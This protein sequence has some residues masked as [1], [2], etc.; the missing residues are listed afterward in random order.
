MSHKAWKILSL[1]FTLNVMCSSPLFA[2][3]LLL[4]IHLFGPQN[5]LL[6]FSFYSLSFPS[7]MYFVQRKH[8]R[9]KVELQFQAIYSVCDIF[10]IFKPIVVVGVLLDV[11]ASFLNIV[12][13]IIFFIFL[14]QS[15]TPSLTLSLFFFI[16]HNSYSNGKCMYGRCTWMEKTRRSSR[17][18]R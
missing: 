8:R 2:L 17:R 4:I 3:E 11:A 13:I 18:R 9:A 12:G 10:Y 6:P 16:F 1:D 7:P 14:T 5:C 15:F